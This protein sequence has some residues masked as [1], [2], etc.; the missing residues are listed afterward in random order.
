MRTMQSM[1]LQGN[2]PDQD[3]VIAV[4]VHGKD[5]VLCEVSL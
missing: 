2:D 3:S 4:M 5:S 1:V